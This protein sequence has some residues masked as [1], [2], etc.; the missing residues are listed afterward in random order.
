MPAVCGV[1]CDT[2]CESSRGVKNPSLTHCAMLRSS[3]SGHSELA[4]GVA[5]IADPIHLLG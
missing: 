2:P 3:F 1:N 5:S 4:P